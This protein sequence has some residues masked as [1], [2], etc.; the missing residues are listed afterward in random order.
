[1]SSSSTSR[2]AGHGDDDDES[3]TPDHWTGWSQRHGNDDGHDDDDE[4]EQ[5]EDYEEHVEDEDDDED[6]EGEEEEDDDDHEYAGEFASYKSLLTPCY[7]VLTTPK[8]STG[9]GIELEVLIEELMGESE[10]QEG[11]QG[12]AQPQRRVLRIGGTHVK[13][14]PR[15]IDGDKADDL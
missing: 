15:R 6:E 12:A 3:Q 9:G 7:S 8:P 13:Q 10:D 4:D 14:A 11:T 2:A 5:D 1:M